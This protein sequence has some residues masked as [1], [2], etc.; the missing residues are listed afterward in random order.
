MLISV[1]V[2]ELSEAL[3]LSEARELDSK[4]NK[5][6]IRSSACKQ[7]IHVTNLAKHNV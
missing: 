3:K 1:L 7:N 5:S 2:N 4:D 6:S